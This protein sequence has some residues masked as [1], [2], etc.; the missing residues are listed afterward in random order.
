MPHRHSAPDGPPKP[1]GGLR[2]LSAQ[3]VSVCSIDQC[4]FGSESG[5]SAFGFEVQAA[6]DREL[7]EVSARSESSLS[8]LLSS[9]SVASRSLTASARPSSVAGTWERFLSAVRFRELIEA[10]K[11]RLQLCHPNARVFA[12]GI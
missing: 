3:A 8:V 10:P 7:A 12:V 9:E 4:V 2:G 11:G 1:W 5:K 6:C